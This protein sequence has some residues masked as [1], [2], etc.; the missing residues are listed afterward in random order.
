MHTAEELNARLAAAGLGSIAETIRGLVRPCYRLTPTPVSDEPLPIGT[1]RFG[2]LPD[3]A[4]GFVWPTLATSKEPAVMEFVGQIKVQDL[5]SPVPEALPPQGLLLFFTRWGE[6]RVF[7]YPEGTPLQRAVSPRPPVAAAPTGILQKIFPGLARKPEP[8]RA[9][10]PCTLTFAAG[11]SLPDGSSSLIGQ[12]G[13]SHA[14][15]ESYV[16]SVLEPL[17]DIQHQMFGYSSPVQNEME[18]EC[19]F[20]RR[21]EEM[22]WNSPPARFVSATR[23]WILLLQVDTDEKDGPGWMW[24]DAG[25]VYFWIHREDLAARAFDKVIC[26]EQCH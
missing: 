14:D 16:E 7:F 23:D 1:S 2:G 19:D 25:I 22:E 13:L 9:Y 11:V 17:P 21:H 4:T 10:R 18:L 20:L 24:G 3:V 8:H 15:A 12:L 6:G 5:P 26:I